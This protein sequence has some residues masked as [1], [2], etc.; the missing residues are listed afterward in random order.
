MQPHVVLIVGYGRQHIPDILHD[1]RSVY[2]LIQR[3][4]FQQSTI[5][6]TKCVVSRSRAT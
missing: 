2:H 6:I 1:M 4:M 3:L 5:L